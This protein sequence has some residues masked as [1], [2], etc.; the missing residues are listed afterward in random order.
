[1]RL[2]LIK[3]RYQEGPCSPKAMHAPLLLKIKSGPSHKGPYKRSYQRVNL[4]SLCEH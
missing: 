2:Q 3:L 1:M 4:L